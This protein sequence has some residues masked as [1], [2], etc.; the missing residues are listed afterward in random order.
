M[1]VDRQEEDG[2]LQIIR[3][4]IDTMHRTHGTID[5]STTLEEETGDITATP[6]VLQVQAVND[7]CWVATRSVLGQTLTTTISPNHNH[8]RK[9]TPAPAGPLRAP[10]LHRKKDIAYHPHVLLRRHSHPVPLVPIPLVRVITGL[11]VLR[12]AMVI[13]TCLIIH[14]TTT[15]VKNHGNTIPIVVEEAITI[16]VAEAE[17][18][19]MDEEIGTVTAGQE[20]STSTTLG[21]TSAWTATTTIVVVLDPIH[22]DRPRQLIGHIHLGHI[23]LARLARCLAQEDGTEIEEEHTSLNLRGLIDLFLLVQEIRIGPSHPEP[24]LQPFR[25][26]N[27]NRAYR[28]SRQPRDHIHRRVSRPGPRHLMREVHHRHLSRWRGG[29]MRLFSLGGR[30]L[31]LM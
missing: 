19:T 1:M 3:P 24:G 13:D 6:A 22:G 31:R 21:K 28:P 27:Q 16:E 23:S 18:I 15:I 14:T 5:T 9:V 26:R 12:R 8:S 30:R 2:I 17:T 29:R 11:L 20:T 4:M 10:H 25:T 7:S